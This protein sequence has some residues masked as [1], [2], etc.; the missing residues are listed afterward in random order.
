ML[1]CIMCI[2]CLFAVIVLLESCCTLYNFQSTFAHILYGIGKKVCLLQSRIFSCVRREFQR[3]VQLHDSALGRKFP[4]AFFVLSHLP[5]FFVSQSLPS[6][7]L[8]VSQENTEDYMQGTCVWL[9]TE[10]ALMSWDRVAGCISRVRVFPNG[11]LRR[12]CF[13]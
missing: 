12:H 8:F 2:S 1:P 3:V 6:P 10:V 11:G 4:R 5:P 7:P 13:S 9:Y